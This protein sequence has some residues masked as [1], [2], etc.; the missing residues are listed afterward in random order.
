MK[1]LRSVALV[2]A[3]VVSGLGIVAVSPAPPATAAYTFFQQG[4]LAVTN[5]ADVCHPED[6]DDIRQLPSSWMRRFHLDDLAIYGPFVADSVTFGVAQ[7][8]PGE[9]VRLRVYRYPAD[10]ATLTWAEL[11]ADTVPYKELSHTLLEGD[12]DRV[13]TLPSPFG[14]FDPATE[15]AVVEIH[16]AGGEGAERFGIGSNGDEQSAPG[17]RYCE[18]DGEIQTMP[19]GHNI[20]ITLNGENGID[21]DVDGDRVPDDPDKDPCAGRAGP[22]MGTYPGCPSFVQEVEATY[23]ARRD[24]IAGTISL[25]GHDDVSCLDP[26]TVSLL[27]ATTND[28]LAA[29]LSTAG[30][31]RTFEIDGRLIDDDAPVR[32]VV[33]TYFDNDEEGAGLAECTGSAASVT[34]GSR[35]SDGDTLPDS[36][37]YC[38]GVF[39]PSGVNHRPGCPRLQ[40]LVSAKVEAGVV[41]G[42]VS[43]QPAADVPAEACAG[44]VTVE[45]FRVEGDSEV[46]VER[47]VSADGEYA[48]S[49]GDPD[50]GATFW[51][52]AY[53]YDSDD[54]AVC[55]RG[56]SEVAEVVRDGDGDG[57]RDNDDLCVAVRHNGP[58]VAAGCPD[59]TRDVTASYADGRLTGTVTFTAEDVPA[60]ACGEPEHT[61]IAVSEFVVTETGQVELVPLTSGSYSPADGSFDLALDL[62]VGRFFQVQ[63]L[64]AL[65]SSHGWCGSARSTP[66]SV[67]E[68][69]LD[70]D[71][72][73]DGAD[74]CPTVAGAAP[75][76][77]PTL[78]RTVTASYDG[79]A[80]TGR[81]SV[82]GPNPA[83]ACLPAR[84]RAFTVA[85]GVA[86]QV[87]ATTDSTATGSYA[88]ALASSLPAGSTYFVSIDSDRHG[89]IAV[90]GAA[91]SDR[92]QV[93]ASRALRREAR[94]ASSAWCRCSR[95]CRLTKKVIHV[96]GARARPRVTRLK[97]G[98]NVAATV[99][100]KVQGHRAR[101]RARR[102]RP[103][104]S[105]PSAAGRS[106]IRLTG[107]IGTKRLPAGH[108]HRHPARH[109]R[110]RRGD[111]TAGRL[112]LRP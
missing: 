61:M 80:I 13:I 72:L 94:P 60:T 95:G 18:S 86:V 62:P 34:A 41:S 88:I 52:R 16:Y 83:A 77:C 78:A 50:D 10:D 49:V 103:R 6:E 69:D 19:A 39:G 107:K 32:A 44:P 1:L 57:W 70:G 28:L 59:L 7:S 65:D 5:A 105:R 36:D 42:A 99:V 40:L 27:D 45:V 111:A 30:T 63:V 106:S 12:T 92:H 14:Q 3:V 47:V 56:D 91:E 35:D 26:V 74:A 101:R 112:R 84:V 87:G 22:R 68:P 82:L 24:V 43:V 64:P 2:L 100:V 89:E 31:S 110:R 109:Q 20:V 29:T 4:S 46:P 67:P 66:G 51:T 48:V 37:D 25:T 23:D 58:S 102:S 96:V 98:L 76:G 11:H 55:L 93:P 33:D 21:S 79:N 71:G 54:L 38:D 8:T 53:G 104:W 108:V 15:D 81:V 75:S 17:Y 73:S 97:L 90:C 9:T 85:N